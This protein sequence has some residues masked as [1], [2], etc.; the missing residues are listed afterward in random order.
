MAAIHRFLGDIGFNTLDYTLLSMDYLI[1][2]L[3]HDI[4]KRIGD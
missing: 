4:L 1:Y 3:K 2:K